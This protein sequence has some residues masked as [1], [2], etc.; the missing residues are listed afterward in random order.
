MW[1][2]KH[3]SG[4]VLFVTSDEHTANNRRDMGWIVEKKECNHEWVSCGRWPD[5][6]Y[7]CMWCNELDSEDED[8]DDDEQR[9]V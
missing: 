9:A 6:Y 2:V 1:A 3:K 5:I 7:K 8:D 4:R